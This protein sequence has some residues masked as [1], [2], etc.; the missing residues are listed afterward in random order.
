MR[1]LLFITVVM[2][3]AAA[4]WGQEPVSVDVSSRRVSTNEIFHISV[5]ANGSDIGEPDMQ[6]V[7]E[8]GITLDTPSHQSST[9]ITS[10]R[11]ATS[12][13]QS[14]T[15]RYPASIA[16][17]GLVTIPRI[18][19]TVDGREYFTQPIDIQ[20]TRSLDMGSRSSEDDT[21]VTIEDL[22]FVRAVTDKDTVYQGEVVVLRLRVYVLDLYYVNLET[23][24]GLPMPD[25]EG[26]YTGQQWQQTLREEY[27]GRPY[28]VTELCQVLYPVASGA[29]SIGA[30]EWRGG[31]RWFDSRRRPQTAA[32]MFR[33]EAVPVTV[34]PL[35][36]P[37]P[38]DFSGAVGRF[39]VDAHLARE[40]VTQGTPVRF[41]VT[42]SGEGNPTTISAPPLPD[43]PWAHVSGPE[44]ET[45]QQDDSVEMTKQFSYLLTP[46]APGVQ[47]VPPVVFTFFAPASGEYESAQSAA[48]SVDVQAAA[49]GETLVAVGG[50]AEEQRRRIDVYDDGLLP[51][52][53]D[54][55]AV[56]ASARRRNTRLGLAAF[57]SPLAPL[58]A[59]VACYIAL[60]HRRRL[61]SDRGYARRY[62]A[63]TTCLKQLTEAAEASDPTETLYRALTGFVGDM[64]N[65]NGAGLT[66]S[67]VESLLRERGAPEETLLI[68][69]RV[70]KACERARYAGRTPSGEELTTLCATATDVVEALHEKLREESV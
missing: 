66:S 19:I 55:Q 3:S 57:M 67:E 47:T 14:R 69:T 46:L 18:P 20:V 38:A 64:L 26:F 37:R 16:R 52:V 29:L 54:P 43:M 39:H 5:S 10:S 15:W 60:Q 53:T 13:V 17:E 11:G 58:L 6:G 23:P 22:A 70:L 1:H 49:G 31:V 12:V 8:A 2:A 4:A 9:S 42:V 65:V 21:E 24:R 27:A 51:I 41:T 56:A 62:Y 32:R 28:R 25:T 30:W 59:L 68:M 35:P 40:Q 61:S 44:V 34:L 7:I 33:T 45:R 48:L 36:T 63:K 50:S